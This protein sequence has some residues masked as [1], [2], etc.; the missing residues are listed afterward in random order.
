[1]HRHWSCTPGNGAV[2]PKMSF[3]RRFSSWLPCA[4]PDEPVAWLYRVVRNGA[5]DV[6]KT[7]RRRKHRETVAAKPEGWFIEPEIDGLDAASAVEALKTLP[8]ELREVIV[9]HLWGG[10]TF[11]QIGAVCNC[12]ASTAHRRYSAA[13]V[14]LRSALGIA[15]TNQTK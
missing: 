14:A 1:M 4:P 11:E 15:C 6:A 3:R 9:A 12:S 5:I 2:R 8:E 10:L 7:S 13:V